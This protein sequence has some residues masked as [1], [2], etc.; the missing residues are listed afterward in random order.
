MPLFSF[1][2]GA[3]MFDATPIENLFL[4]EYLPVAPEA[5]LRVYLYARMLAL[6]PELGGDAAEMA[7]ALRLDEA[8]IHDAFAYWEQQGLARRLTDRPPT[9]ELI[10]PRVEGQAA[11]NPMERD[12]YAYRDFN[13]SLQALFRE[14]V[15]ESHEYRIAND[16][17]NVLGYEQAAALRLVEYGIATSRAKDRMPSPPSVFKRMDK[18][19]AAWADRGCRTLE[20]VERAIAEDEGVYAVARKVL[21]C[22]S[23]TRKP[24]QPELECAK[25]W[26]EEW[27]YTEDEIIEACGETRNA[28]NPSFGYL[29]SILKNRLDGDNAYWRECAEVLR[30]LD[31]AQA[32][33]TPDQ[34]ARYAALREAG[35][36]AATVKLAAVQC[37]RRK[38][39]RLEDVERMLEKWGREGIHTHDA[40]AAYVARM[41]R[42]AERV[43]ALLEKTGSERRVRM[44]DLAMYDAWRAKHDDALID[45]AAECARGAQLPM[46]YMDKLLGDWEA[47]GI[48]TPE[49]ARAQR[50]ANRA[51]RATAKAADRAPANPALDY[52][53]REYRDE[54]F[55][56]DFFIDLD[57]YGEGGDKA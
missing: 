16:W 24:T 51:G 42:K 30:E 18:I 28:K 40:A 15:I 39:T 6:H 54:D 32:Q 45:C 23:Q 48:R 34:L 3:A 36:E 26:L 56:D 57:K 55:G 10:P 21:R 53:Q 4:M 50:G 22:F 13:A 27:H 9:Y 31:A 25:R 44:D 43:A 29:D 46:K 52:A 7:R 17:L 49:A 1:S 38:K 2:D 14:R 35:F 12:Y 20:D 19:A 11:A 41:Q 33:P 8:V 47:A 5:F 37:R